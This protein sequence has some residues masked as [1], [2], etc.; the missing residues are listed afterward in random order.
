MDVVLAAMTPSG[1]V[2]R[3][4]PTPGAHIIDVA[5]KLVSAGLIDIQV[6]GGYGHDFTHS[7]DSIWLVGQQLVAHGVTAFLPTIVSASDQTIARAQQVITA[8][9]PPLYAGS[10]HLASIWRAPSFP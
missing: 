3:D 5:G 2:E 10:S 7:P 4:K 9:P 8:G 1:F 6:N